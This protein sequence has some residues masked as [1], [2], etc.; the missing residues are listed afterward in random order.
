M[1]KETYLKELRK[2]LKVLD[3]KERDEVIAFYEEY[4][5]DAGVENEAK[6]IEEFGTPKELSKKILVDVVNRRFNES[7][8]EEEVEDKKAKN[9]SIRGIWV[10]L[11][12]LLALPLSPILLALVIVLA[13]IAFAIVVTIIAVILSGALV[14]GVGVITFGLGLTLLLSKFGA[15]ITVIG[16]GLI[17]YGVGALLVI[18]FAKLL[19]LF[20]YAVSRGFAALVHK[21]N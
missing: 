4:F 20:C 19:S 18:G 12:A 9:S 16:C 6:V 14:V 11:A 1:N 17:C 8:G 21:N 3:S 10:V 2:N 7:E 13:A 5:D 15:A